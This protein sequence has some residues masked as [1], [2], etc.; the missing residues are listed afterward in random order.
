MNNKPANEKTNCPADKINIKAS[1]TQDKDTLEDIVNSEEY[2]QALD[3][4]KG[5][6]LK[7]V[8]SETK[9]RSLDIKMLFAANPVPENSKNGDEEPENRSKPANIAIKQPKTDDIDVPAKRRHPNLLPENVSRVIKPNPQITVSQLFEDEDYID[10]ETRLRYG[11]KPKKARSLGIK[12]MFAAANPDMGN[13]ASINTQE[14]DTN[15]PA[16][17]D[18][19]LDHQYQI[20]GTGKQVDMLSHACEVMARIN[21]GQVSAIIDT[22]ELKD[23]TDTYALQQRLEQVIQPYLKRR[24]PHSPYFTMHQTLRHRRSWDVHPA[25]GMTVNFDEPLILTDDPLL[26]I[27][28]LPVKELTQDVFIDQPDHILSAHIDE[29][30]AAY[31]NQCNIDQ[32]T[33]CSNGYVSFVPNTFQYCIGRGFNT[34]NW[35]ASPINRV[36]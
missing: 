20:R 34:D 22:L 29:N 6:D 14:D 27:M 10:R 24:I 23:D 32:L 31:I 15:K 9:E 3:Y 26:E 1:P 21:M 4:M 36:F 7:P 12:M 16:K 2:G 33:L 5:N 28:K 8:E 25:G 30:G 11:L 19:L 18:F 17:Y 13:K 35:Q